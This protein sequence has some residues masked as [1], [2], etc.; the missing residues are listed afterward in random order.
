MREK[1]SIIQ[2]LSSVCLFSL[3]CWPSLLFN[4]SINNFRHECIYTP[5]SLHIFLAQDRGSIIP[6]KDRAIQIS[7]LSASHSRST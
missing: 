5:L 6:R 3:F 7:H 1:L 4:Q 2:V